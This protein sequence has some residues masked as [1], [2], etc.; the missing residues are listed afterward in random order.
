MHNIVCLL[1]FIFCIVWGSRSD[2]LLMIVVT[3]LISI[4]ILIMTASVKTTYFKIICPF[5]V[6]FSLFMCI[7]TLLINIGLIQ[8]KWPLLASILRQTPE[9]VAITYYL[10]ASF[11]AS[12]FENIATSKKKVN[13]YKYPAIIYFPLFIM[14]AFLFSISVVCVMIVGA[15]L[16]VL[17]S[18]CFKNRYLTGIILIVA[19]LLLFVPFFNINKVANKDETKVVQVD[20]DKESQ[21]ILRRI[22]IWNKSFYSIRITDEAPGDGTVQ[23]LSVVRHPTYYPTIFLALRDIVGKWAYCIPL[24]LLGCIARITTRALKYSDNVHLKMLGNIMAYS[25]FVLVLADWMFPPMDNPFKGFAFTCM[26]AMIGITV[27]CIKEAKA[28][29]EKYYTLSN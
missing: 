8:L 11:F 3:S 22:N 16:G 18:G 17:A 27:S 20:Q 6:F 24:L 13:I 7:F 19:V 1:G 25:L 4:I 21:T 12:A 23:E 29:N 14:L 2:G 26:A 15:L 28:E 9:I 10:V 5:L